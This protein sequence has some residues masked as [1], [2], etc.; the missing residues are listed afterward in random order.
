MSRE[1]RNT[2]ETILNAAWR[3]LEAAPGREVRMSDIA[4]EAGVSRQAV[5]GHFPTRADLLTAT[6]RYLDEVKNVDAR[7]A[8]S[9]NAARGVDRLAAF[10]E[11]WGDYIPEIY[12]VGRAFMAMYDS[13]S[14]AAAAWDDRM[15]AVRHGCQAAVDALKRDGD[16]TPDYSAR[17]ATDVLWTLLSV[18]NWERLRNDCGWSQKRYVETM[19]AIAFSALVAD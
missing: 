13:D 11:A 17:Q 19:K 14:E 16:L 6:A 4:A 2:R 9:R 12:G 18:E 10:V 15:Q 8:A 5:Y 3:L 7:L 1:N